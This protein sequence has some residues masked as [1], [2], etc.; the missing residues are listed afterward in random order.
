MTDRQMLYVKPDFPR[1][2]DRNRN[3][4]F[5]T[6]LGSGPVCVELPSEDRQTVL[7]FLFPAQEQFQFVFPFS[8]LVCE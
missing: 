8:V 4:T 6:D 5:I 3:Q 1:S 2:K 7:L